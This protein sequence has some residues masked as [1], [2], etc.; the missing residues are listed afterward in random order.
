MSNV[1]YPILIIGGGLGGLSLAQGL[2][3]K[4]IRFRIF[5]R[6]GA[7]SFRAQ[8]YRIRLDERGIGSLE[9]LLPEPLFDLAERTSSSVVGGGH[10]YDALTGQKSEARFG[11]GPPRGGTGPNW[12]VDRT[13]IRN[14]LLQGLEE[15]IEYG[16]RLERYDL[17]PE[18]VTA[19]FS[20]GTSATGR[21]VIGADGV[22]S[23]VRR[24]LVPGHTLLD[25]EMRAV[26]GKTPIPEGIPAPIRDT[27]VQGINVTSEEHPQGR[28]VLFCDTM[29]FK[30]DDAEKVVVPD[31]YI[32]WVLTFAKSRTEVDDKTLM[33]FT[34]DQSAKLAE[35]LTKAWNES[36]RAVVTKQD[37][38]AA[39]TLFFLMARP[40]LDVW[41]TDARVTLL[42]DAAHSMPPLGGVGANSAFEDAAELAEVLGRGEVGDE[43]IGAYEK[44][45][46]DQASGR[47][48]MSIAGS[49]KLFGMRP[50]EELKP[51]AL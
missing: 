42:G 32:Y 6:D 38:D 29:R 16:K 25:T 2:K 24:Q 4:G 10:R 13:V 3:K 35:D 40:D 1:S 21:M 39:S 14:V 9:K 41:P 46:R 44:L 23:H 18:Q 48:G 51:F 34:S 5:E 19:H 12:N 20:D 49:A 47:L 30:H 36:D 11:G 50:I 45:V 28:A 15:D 8:G 17:A 7:A 22:R 43:E 26:F 31:D 37:P 33:S 27:V